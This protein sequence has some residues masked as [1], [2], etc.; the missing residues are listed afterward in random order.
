MSQPKFE[1]GQVVMTQG[2]R[3]LPLTVQPEVARALSR[4]AQGDWGDTPAEDAALNEE[5]VKDG[6][7]VMSSY[8]I[9]GERIWIIT[10]VVDA[11][12]GRA[13]TLLLPEEY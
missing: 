6:G 4:H 1:L 10:E 11:D 2:V 3:R 13:T 9:G 7:R 8:K 12:G 5:A